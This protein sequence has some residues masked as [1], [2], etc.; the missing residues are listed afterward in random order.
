MEEEGKAHA[1]LRW[2][3]QGFSEVPQGSAAIFTAHLLVKKPAISEKNKQKCPA[4]SS[5][6]RVKTG[7]DVWE[8]ALELHGFLH[9]AGHH[10]QVY[11]PEKH[12]PAK[13][14]TAPSRSWEEL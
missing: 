13:D 12:A 6:H 2:Q 8:V 1:F 7:H 9:D 10:R 14:C 4:N 11:T 5:S 3:G